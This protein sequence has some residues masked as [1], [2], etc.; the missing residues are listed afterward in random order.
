MSS[1]AFIV[2][3]EAAEIERTLVQENKLARI[4]IVITIFSAIFVVAISEWAVKK[5]TG[6]IALSAF[7]S[8]AGSIC[9]YFLAPIWFM[10]WRQKGEKALKIAFS[11]YLF[12]LIL[13]AA[14]DYLTKSGLRQ[15][16]HL[17]Q[18]VS[19][20]GLGWGLL[21]LLPWLPLALLAKS[22]P[23]SAQRIGLSGIGWKENI[24]IGLLAGA[25]LG[26]HMLLVVTAIGR[27]LFFNPWP[28]TVWLLGYELGIQSL[29]EELFFR[30][31]LF[32]Y[33]HNYRGMGFWSSA[34]LS[35]FLN[36]AVYMV[37]ALWISYAPLTMGA[38]FYI[39]TM[40]V[41]N[42]VLF[43]WRGSILSCWA[44]NAL[45]SLLASLVVG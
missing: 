42:A 4:F 45:F 43:R 37:K 39:M 13:M 31:F 19:S 3:E 21:M 34:F 8:E 20:A 12:S 38:Q 33:W 10:L 18:R 32:N 26:A 25:F 9:L 22:Y 29:G 5:P 16:L 27:K 17:S 36:V 30:G 41:T 11:F 1:L 40:A 7:I 28:Y 15:E 35:G 6:N 14:V 2:K 23:L 24:F 44:S